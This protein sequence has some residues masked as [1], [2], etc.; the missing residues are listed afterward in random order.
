M[1]W[2]N[3]RHSIPPLTSTEKRCDLDESSIPAASV[4]LSSAS[5]RPFSAIIFD[6]DG[7]LVD[8]MPLHY[9]AYRQVFNTLGLE[10]SEEHFYKNIGGKASETI[11]LF[12]AGRDPGIPVME[13]HHRKK[14]VISTLFQDAPLKVCPA[15]RFL[16]IFK[17]I[18]PIALVSA[19]SRPGI[20]QL[21]TRLG[22]SHY[23]DVIITGEDTERSKP[24][25]MPYL[26]ASSRLQVAPDLTAV[27]EDTASGLESARRAGM[28]AFNVC[29]NPFC[30]TP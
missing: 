24:D 25:P 23:F 8:T 21:L 27:F 4:Q 3:T 2:S 16:P 10:L 26:L 22:W 19:G 29:D 12:L 6:F 7:T 17:K 14:Q 18:L 28:I 13:I 20:M 5:P 30:Q 1:D 15:A 11:P 9:E